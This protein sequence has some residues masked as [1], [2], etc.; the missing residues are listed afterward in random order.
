MNFVAQFGEFFGENLGRSSDS[1]NAGKIGVGHQSDFQD[2]PFLRL[3]CAKHPF[4]LSHF[5][6]F[7][8]NIG[9]GN[10]EDILFPTALNLN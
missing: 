2:R 6:H 4:S 5:L 7:R 1:V 10:F 3:G 9:H 8:Q